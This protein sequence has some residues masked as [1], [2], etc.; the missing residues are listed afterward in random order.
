MNNVAPPSSIIEMP[1]RHTV[2]SFAFQMIVIAFALTE[3]ALAFTVQQGW[4][5]LAVPL[6][7]LLGHIMHG[8]SVGFHEATH[9]LLRRNR[10][11]N[12][13]DGILIGVIGLT[14]FSLY[15]AAH[16]THHAF[17]S[18]ERDEELWPFIDPGKP[19][20][21]RQLAALLELNLGMLFTPLLFYRT[22]LRSGSPIRNHKVRRRIW[23]EI[24]LM[25]GIW[26]GILCAVTY[27]Q[28]WPW[29]I[30]LY[31][32]PAALAANLQSWRKYIE[33]V[34]LTGSTVNGSTR[35]IVSHTVL[36]RF[37]DFSLLHEPYH[38]LHHLH[39]GVPHDALPRFVSE[40]AP[41]RADEQPLYSSYWSA[42]QHLLR[43]L[44]DPRV[45]AQWHNPVNP[46]EHA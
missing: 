2:N 18:S 16:Q 13:F 19:R 6:V 20:W 8:A 32:L 42:L 45:G 40:L 15:R 34:G 44:P 28:V 26:S 12:E 30:W 38:G 14:S 21:I 1:G 35:S 25:L 24:A 29:F 39:P 22:F 23:L 41:Q 37:F 27:W 4:F 36:G 17:L 5:W 11:L 46:P 33:H 3:M 31:L 9:G 7:L 43:N 10:R